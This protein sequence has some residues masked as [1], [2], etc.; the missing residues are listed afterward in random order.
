MD[1]KGQ[2]VNGSESTVGFAQL[3]GFDRD[4]PGHTKLR[5]NRSH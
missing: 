3:E 4:G 2:I 5:L 1:L